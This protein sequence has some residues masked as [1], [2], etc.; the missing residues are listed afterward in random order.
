MLLQ[1]SGLLKS[2]GSTVIF[3]QLSLQIQSRQR[4]GLIGAN[5][6]GKSTLLRILAGESPYD[7]GQLFI[8]KATTIGYLAQNSGLQSAQ[9]IEQEMRSIFTE[10][11]GIEQQLRQLEHQIAQMSPGFDESLEHKILSS[12]ATLSDDFRERGGFAIEANIRGVLHGMG[13]KDTDPATLVSILSGGQKTRLALAK[14]LLQKPDLLLLDEPTNHLDMDTLAWLESY[15]R[16]Y[17]GTIMVVS[18]DRYFLD[19][20]VDT[21]Y[22]MDRTACRRYTGNYSRYLELKSAEYEQQMKAYERQQSE[23]IRQEQFIQRNIARA[24]TTRRAQSRRTMLDR[25]ERLDRPGQALRKMGVHFDIEEMSGQDVLDAHN[26]ATPIFQH[27]QLRLRRGDSA[28]II[29]PNGIGKSTLLKVLLGMQSPQA[30][31]IHWG[32][33]VTIGYYDQEQADLVSNQSVLD[34]VWNDY[35]HEEEMTIR[36]VLGHFLFSGDDVL[37]KIADLSGG[38]KARVALA[39]LMLRKANV[40]ILDEPTNHLDLA[41][42]EVLE[43]AL[44]EYEGTLLFISHD[45]YFLNRMADHVYELQSNGLFHFLGNYDDYVSKKQEERENS[46]NQTSSL[47]KIHAIPPAITTYESEKLAKREERQR[48]R[49]LEQLELTITALENEVSSIETHLAD[50]IIYNNYVTVQ[51]L[52]ANIEEIKTQLA[53]YYE[54]WETLLA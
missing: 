19:A 49:R 51:Q 26:L 46:A 42:K 31:T 27:I 4:I 37:K 32:A 48:Q 18:H 24:S 12:Y 3:S 28:A 20:L 52:Q 10:L 9:S 15:L 35:P 30:G 29:G 40:L 2:Y 38:E 43:T 33:N 45:R 34:E 39:K 50:P 54:E 17:S 23:I 41:S 22:E 8:A 44:M 1:A 11:Y 53:Q 14:L 36:T 7:E 25:I 6:A 16:N 21:I 47:T 5:G 13:F